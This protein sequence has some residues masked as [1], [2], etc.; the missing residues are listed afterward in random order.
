MNASNPEEMALE[1][2]R[3][4]NERDWKGLL[5]MMAED[6][7]F[8]GPEEGDVCEG[9]EAMGKGF[10]EYFDECPEYRIHVSKVTRSGDSIAFVGR[11]TGSHIDPKIEAKETVVFIATISNG[12]VAQWR[13]FS[14]MY[15][16]K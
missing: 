7:R 11:T 12:S 10:R 4:I 13:I 16:L 8:V 15:H 9:R 6:F 5:D 2:V 3:R 1:F 14:D